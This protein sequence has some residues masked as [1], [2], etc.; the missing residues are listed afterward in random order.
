MNRR[1]FLRGLLA[2]PMSAN[3]LGASDG[4]AQTI[5]GLIS[6]QEA[7]QNIALLP[8]HR[9]WLQATAQEDLA[10]GVN[11]HVRQFGFDYARSKS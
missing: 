5:E 11:F 10:Y 8:K 4:A 9:V 6:A 3:A 2:A 1:G 7:A